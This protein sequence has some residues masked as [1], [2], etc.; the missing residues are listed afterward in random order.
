MNNFPQ[1]PLV[2][3]VGPTNAGKS[4]LFNRLTGS[5]QA[6]TAKEE[7]TTRDRVF[8]EVDW[9]GNRFNLVDTAGL[10]N[11]D[12]E[13]YQLIENQRE[14]AIEEADLILFVFDGRLGL[15]DKDQRLLSRLRLVKPIFLI[16]NK[17]DSPQQEQQSLDLSY[18]GFPFA[19]ISAH[20]GRA[21][22]DLLERIIGQLPKVE[23]Q[24]LKSSNL[25]ALVG[26]PNVGKST[27]LNSLT[28]SL[29]SVVSPIAGTTR[30]VVSAKLTIEGKEF[31]LA[32]TAGIRRRGRI[33][34][35]VE[36]FSVKRALEI[37]HR[38]QQV[39]VI[40]DAQEGL[41]R[42]DLH[43]IY[44]AQ[45]LEKPILVLINKSDLVKAEHSWPKRKLVK[46]DVL[47][48]S[49]LKKIN[50]DKVLDWILEHAN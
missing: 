43:L 3:L 18:L 45:Q 20:N 50:L 1:L 13:L 33:Q 34:V 6:V 29:R 40:T 5:F 25:I 49:A 16:A 10:A 42:G 46:F 36:K 22:A 38:S 14:M 2:A 15:S 27:L 23:R 41:T 19:E 28:N 9:Q 4:T 30:D 48:I 31:E 35:G 32:D 21:V 39:I 8:G 44:F 26:R 17:I 7:S 24:K 12:S 47:P 37:I 11:D